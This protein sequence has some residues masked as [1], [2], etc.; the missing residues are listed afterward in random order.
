MFVASALGAGISAASSARAIY[1]EP[2][3]GL[4]LC[5]TASLRHQH[6]L[7]DVPGLADV[8]VGVGG[9]VEGEGLGD[10]RLQLACREVV[11]ERLDEA[12]QVALRVPPMEHVEAE[13]P[14]VLVH[15]SKALPP[16]DCRQR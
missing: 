1:A 8:A 10:D 2:I 15:K 11:G 7:A 12:V 14:L 3:R 5:T 6:H 16:R 13:D 4:A 9:A